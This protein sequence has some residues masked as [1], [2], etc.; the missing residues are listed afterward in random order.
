MPTLLPRTGLP[1]SFSASITPDNHVLRH[2]RVDLA[3]QFDEPRGQLV[4]AGQ[5]AQVER[6]DR[7]A[8]PAQAG[9]G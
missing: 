4:L 3:G 1:T 5:P 2:A 9:P 7:D 6:V 8:V